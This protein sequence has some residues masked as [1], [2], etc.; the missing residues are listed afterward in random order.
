MAPAHP[1][2][3]AC[4]W[5]A[6]PLS[7]GVA[8]T[9]RVRCA[10]CGVAT[11][12]PWP[13][14][15]ELEAAYG[16]WY[17]P[18]EGRFS[19]VGDRLLRRLRGRLAGRIDA[20]APPGP[21]LDIGSGDGA[22]LSALRLRGR[23]AI[24]LERDDS[25]GE[26]G[27]EDILEIEETGWSGVVFWHSLEHLRAPAEALRKAATLLQPNG[28]LIVALPNAASLQ[29][30][31][32]GDRWF[33]LDLPR[34]LVHV[35]SRAVLHTIRESGLR[36]HR[37]SYSRG[38]QVLFGWLHGLVGLLPGNPDLYD[39]IRR[40]SAR[41]APMSWRTRWSSLAAAALVLPPAVIAALVEVALRR[42]GTVYVEAR[43]A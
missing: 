5:C 38:G 21:I 29:A 19:G 24:G 8:L 33:A 23:K 31:L 43:R 14:D 34:H 41:S 15:L 26:G 4:A 6:Y 3:A 30:R 36:I 27:S 20:I 35:P 9:G 11:T 13:S 10:R 22:L 17:R 16:D 7:E 32:F 40:P 1:A 2:E 12:Q 39:A 28:V 25:V 18:A 37:I 42:G